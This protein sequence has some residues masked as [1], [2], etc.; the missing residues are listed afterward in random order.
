[1]YSKRR[2]TLI[3]LKREHKF[4]NLF[5]GW[6]LLFSF[7]CQLLIL[8]CYYCSFSWSSSTCWF[9]W[10]WHPIFWSFMVLI[11]GFIRERAEDIM[12]I[13]EIRGIIYITNSEKLKTIK[14]IAKVHHGGERFF[15]HFLFWVKEKSVIYLGCISKIWITKLK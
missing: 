2:N 6:E 8:S 12:K 3:Y 15:L 13:W 1:M 14:N 10:T 4:A 7:S 9:L 5:K 11:L